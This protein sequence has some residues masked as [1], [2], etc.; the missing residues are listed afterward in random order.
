VALLKAPSDAPITALALRED[1]SGHLA[2]DDWNEYAV[3][4]D[5]PNIWVLLNGTP[6][7]SA[8]DTVVDRGWVAFGVKRLGS[9]DDNAESAVVF[10]D[11]RVSRLATGQ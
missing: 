8:S 4:L 7:L 2:R 11:L 3:R 9:A 5:G 1:L 10:R 6:I